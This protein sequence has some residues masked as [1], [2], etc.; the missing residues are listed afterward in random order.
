LSR[1]GNTRFR[2][3]IPDLLQEKTADTAGTDDSGA[4]E[5]RT[6]P[7]CTDSEPPVV[8]RRRALRAGKA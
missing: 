1:C 2:H 4:G 5:T 7:L 8:T 3:S 6:E